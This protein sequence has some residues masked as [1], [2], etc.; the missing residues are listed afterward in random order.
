MAVEIRRGTDRFVERLPG[1]LTLHAFSF[2]SSYD[3]DHVRF[4]PMV[5][6]DDHLLRVGEGFAPHEHADL[7]IVTWVVSGALDHD[8]PTGAAR[9][10]PGQV[11]V[12]RTGRGVTHAEVAAAPQTRFVQVWLAASDEAGPSAP[13]YD[14]LTPELTPGTLVRVA[15]P[16]P[17][18]VLSVVRLGDHQSVV[19]PSGPRTHVYVARGALL[20][21]SL[22]EPL[23]EGDAFLFT[24]EPDTELTAG[25]PTD[26]LVWSFAA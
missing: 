20:R 19:I 1:R 16:E 9:V 15:E 17:G 7:S 2:G 14:V 25:V 6:H 4:G 8:G 5:C 22:A 12:L 11:A 10:E 24:D 3:A 13:T 26:L 21:S 18:A 23:H